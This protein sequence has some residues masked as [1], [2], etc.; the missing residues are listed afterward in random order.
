MPFLN[1]AA[2]YLATLA[3]AGSTAVSACSTSK[4]PTDGG[5]DAGGRGGHGGDTAGTGGAAG[6]TGGH[7]GTA[8]TGGQSDAGACRVEGESCTSPQHCCG[9]LICAGICTMGV[10]SK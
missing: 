6:G 10:G 9:P 1:R 5:V 4:G 8:G 3:L 7:A 2:R